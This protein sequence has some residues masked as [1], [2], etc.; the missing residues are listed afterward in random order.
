MMFNMILGIFWF[1]GF[2][3]IYCQYEYKE[4]TDANFPAY[5]VLWALFYLVLLLFSHNLSTYLSARIFGFWF[6]SDELNK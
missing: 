2:Y 1:F 6:Y 3:G 4:A 5:C